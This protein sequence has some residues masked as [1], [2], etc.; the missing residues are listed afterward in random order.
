MTKLGWRMLVE[1]DSLWEKY[2]LGET[3][4]HK[5]E[6]KRNSSNAWRGIGEAKSILLKGSK[7]LVHDG[8][9]TLFWRNCWLEGQPPIARCVA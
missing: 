5:I 1:K 7:M 3:K 6:R 2:I 8:K 4:A 9:N